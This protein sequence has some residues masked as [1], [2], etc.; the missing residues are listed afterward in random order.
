MTTASP[1]L[2]ALATFPGLT[3]AVERSHNDIGVPAPVWGVGA[4]GVLVLLLL[5][6]L[7]LGK[8]KPHS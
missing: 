4:F 1:T 2:P 5:I 6:T 8:G 7:M 3:A